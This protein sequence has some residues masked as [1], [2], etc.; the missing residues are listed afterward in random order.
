MASSS[1]FCS[2]KSFNKQLVFC[3]SCTP[4]MENKH[5]SR[6][7]IGRL[8]SPLR[9]DMTRALKLENYLKKSADISAGII[10]DV[11]SINC[12]NWLKRVYSIAEISVAFRPLVSSIG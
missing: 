8:F 1:R 2:S 7:L 10:R 12:I 5:Q 9:N 6:G 3:G 4:D 11:S